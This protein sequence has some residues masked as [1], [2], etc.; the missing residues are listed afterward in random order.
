MN[1]KVKRWAKDL[2]CIFLGAIVFALG[3]NYFIIA[4]H[5]AEGGVTGVALILYYL[6]GWSV[7]HTI[8][9]LNIPLFIVGWRLVGREFAIKSVFGTMVA[10]LAINLTHNL[11]APMPEDLLL[12]A[13][14]GGGVIG[15]GMGTIFLFGGS[16]G[17][18]DII[19]RVVNHRWGFPIG[20]ALLMIDIV[21]ITAVGLFFGRVVAMYTLVAIFVAAQIIDFVQTGA[22]SAKAAMIISDQSDKIA[23][24][25][26]TE[27]ERGAT[28][29]S[30]RGAYTALE[31]NVLYCVVSR[32]EVFRLKSV[33]REV[34]PKA[35][36]IINEVH[37][38]L[39]E[40]FR[41]WQ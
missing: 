41:S 6:F 34:D 39:G 37:E 28:V 38:V 19:A 17:G 11:Q 33:V 25:V 3:I 29:L 20:R 15:L 2:T 10:A 16:T 4:N 27:L 9:I 13:L 12:A 30:G 31:K 24:R 36:M 14:Y 1:Q 23:H 8:I 18:A 21:V 32:T 26:A 35:F 40:G 22:Y 5:L 7:G